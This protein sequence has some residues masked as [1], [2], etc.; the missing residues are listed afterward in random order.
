MRFYK[1]NP[2]VAGE[3]FVCGK[4]MTDDAVVCG[5][6]FAPFADP[7]TFPGRPPKLVEV[8]FEDLSDDEKLS[9]RGVAIE[10]ASK[11][12]RHLSTITS[13][14]VAPQ[15]GKNEPI[16]IVTSPVDMGTKPKEP[17]KKPEP[18]KV[19]EERDEEISKA[20]QDKMP[21]LSSM[22]DRE[23]LVEVFPG[24]TG[25]NATKVFKS[26]K[27]LEAMATASNA[28]LR[29]AGIQPNFFD[30]VRKT[31]QAEIKGYNTLKK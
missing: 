2:E 1:K 31:A 11:P 10:Q 23:G 17:P 30:R 28:E 16:K 14:S 20:F 6:E 7:K 3:P 15:A 21:D 9:A 12:P 8:S 27:N 18:P 5:E 29:K 4:Q 25:K 24:I 19:S 26:F 22:Y 13:E